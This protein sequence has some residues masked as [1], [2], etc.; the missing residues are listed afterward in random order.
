MK[1]RKNNIIPLIITSILFFTYVGASLYSVQEKELSSLLKQLKTYEEGKNDH[2]VLELNAYMRSHRATKEQRL[3][4]ERQL[5]SF[6]KTDATETAKMLACRHLRIIGTKESIPVLKDMVLKKETTDMARYAL[7]KIPDTASDKALLT[8]LDQSSGL[9]KAGIISSLGHRKFSGA[10][11]SLKKILNENTYPSL[12]LAAAEA[13]GHIRNPEAAEALSNALSQTEGELKVQVTGSLLKCAEQFLSDGENEEASHIYDRILSA[14][15][16]SSLHNSAIRGKINAAGEKGTEYIL[17]ALKNNKKEINP[18]YIEM[19][20]E[21]FDSSNITSV[22]VLLPILPP[23]AKV[24]VISVLSL[25]PGKEVRQAVLDSAQDSSSEVRIASLKTL[26]QIGDS[27]I[28]AFLAQRAASSK[29]EEK[30]QARTSLWGLKGDDIDSTVISNLN[31]EKT[32]EIQIEYLKTVEQRRIYS[33][34]DAVFNTL[35]S[36]SPEVRLQAIRSMKQISSKED[37]PKLLEFLKKT[38]N[39]PDRKEMIYTIAFTALKIQDPLNRG[40]P[41]KTVLPEVKDPL[42]RSS[43]Y[44]L[45]GRIGDDSTLPVL[46]SGLSEKNGMV[47]DSIV[48]AFASWPTSTAAEDVLYIAKTSDKPEHRILCLRAY[49]RMIEMEPYQRPEAA[50]RSLE[51]ALN[52]TKRAQEKIMILG[53]LQKFPCDRAANLAE[54]LTK[55]SDVEKEAK[56]T[57]ILIKEKLKKGVE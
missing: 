40:E 39:D 51:T 45:L 1:K 15:L 48:R 26:K 42:T 10:V 29:G 41:V 27:S 11:P 16:P 46:R 33:G 55:D 24:Q 30:L 35:R 57:L 47:H 19:I 53:V 36:S 18:S 17:E 22:C 9:I 13:L 2:L 7:E 50:V 12:S 20:P 37:I 44:I 52:L 54:Q 28:V 32:P 4:C 49:I 21:Y 6:L 31:S 43:L 34:K 3:E 38:E 56:K 23:W 14:D 8:A 25:Y 5:L